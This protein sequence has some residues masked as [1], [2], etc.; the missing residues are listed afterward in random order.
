MACRLAADVLQG[1]RAVGVCETLRNG[2]GGP[3]L[4][5]RLARVESGGGGM[6]GGGMNE[7][8]ELSLML[9]AAVPPSA[10]AHRLAWWLSGDDARWDRLVRGAGV[11]DASIDRML[12]GELVPA[13]D[14]A[15]AIAR[16]SEGA[17]EPGDW[18]R[19]AGGGWAEK[20]GARPEGAA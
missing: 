14:V 3:I 12:S 17:V 1:I 7:P 11:T 2:A 9:G 4:S 19:G 13:D 10:G 8:L 20:P 5:H 6:T 16:E 15:A 18:T